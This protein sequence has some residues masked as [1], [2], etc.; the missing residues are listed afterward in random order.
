MLTSTN[1]SAIVGRGNR[2]VPAKRI[3]P[4]SDLLILFPRFLITVLSPLVLS[5]SKNQQCYAADKR[6]SSYDRWQRN[7]SGFFRR[8]L[9]W[10]D[11]DHFFSRCVGDPLI[12]KGRDSE[13]YKDDGKQ[14]GCFHL[15]LRY[16]FTLFYDLPMVVRFF[17]SG[18]S[19]PAL[20]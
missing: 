15:I 2:S 10:T 13:G 18:R 11:V 6:N 19:R 14:Y 12:C 4:R 3:V 17:G 7:G 20:R 9:Q 1:T 5:A 16:I 8:H